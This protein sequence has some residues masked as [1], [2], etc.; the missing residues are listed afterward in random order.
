MID[1]SL[2]RAAQAPLF[3]P[4]TLPN[5][6]DVAIIG[7]GITGLTAALLLKRSGRTVAVFER[8][9][10]GAGDTGNTSAHVTY[11]TD[12]LLSTLAKEVGKEAV[13]LVWRGEEAAID[14][15]E[16][17]AAD[18]I[19]CGFQRVPGF[20]CAPFFDPVTPESTEMLKHEAAA[21]AD[22][23]FSARFLDN[24]PLT[25][26]PAISFADQAVYHPLDYIFG[27]ASRVDGDGSFV[28]ERCEVGEVIDDP[29]AV[30]VNGQTIACTDLVIATHE[31]MVGIRN[32]AAATL[33]Q[34]KLYAYSTYVLGA[35]LDNT[36]APG[37]YNDTSDP[38]FYF[39]VHEDSLGRYGIFGGADHKTGQ[40]IDTDAHF[41]RLTECFLRLV[42]SARIER[43]WSG[44]VIE[45]PDGL[46]YIGNVTDHQY[47]ATA[48]AGNGMTFGTLA[49][50]LIRDAITGADNL[51][52]EILDPHR[53]AASFDAVKRLIEE[54][55]DYPLYLIGD[56]LRGDASGVENV[57]RGAGK[58][59]KEKGH[60]VA[61]HRRDDGSV[62]KVSAVCTHM[63][64][65]V[66]WNNAERTW[67]CPCHGSRFTPEGLVLAGPAEAPLSKVE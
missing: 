15:I 5:T 4:A 33:F 7:G 48:Y 17:N 27:L 40:E 1:Q 44:Q 65:L 9:R 35:R 30:I 64:C 57:P 45:S 67:D 14:L 19:Q 55:V 12:E 62:V 25:G 53:K 56:R 26:K 39:R 50:M 13:E 22:G 21:A 52:L 20:I 63:G 41:A 3:K 18:G 59:I 51:L 32:L 46:P 58:V 34:T 29:L 43:R 36:I 54:N 60:R 31:P 38:Y 8:E 28:C 42:P 6:V 2:W 16:E 66:R 24:G 37:L 47:V 10:L 11:V 61:V 23:G 49:G